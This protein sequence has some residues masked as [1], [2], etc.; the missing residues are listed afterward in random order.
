MVISKVDLVVHAN[1]NDFVNVAMKEN[2]GFAELEYQKQQEIIAK[3]GI[4]KLSS[5][6][7]AMV[8]PEPPATE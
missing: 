4:D 7:T 8:E 5:M 6:N 2:K 1:I 3:F